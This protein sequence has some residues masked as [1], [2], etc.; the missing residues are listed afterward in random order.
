MAAHRLPRETPEEQQRRDEA[1]QQAL[2]AAV[3]APLE[4]AR[5]AA[6]LFERLGQ[7][8]PMA[9]PSMLSDVRVG[10]MMAATAVRGALENAATNLADITDADFANR[11]RSGGAQ[12]LASRVSESSVAT[13]R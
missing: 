5:R 9:G 1:I 11:V 6:K 2:Q 10:R 4:I 8:E 13:G 7:L 12:S 3:E